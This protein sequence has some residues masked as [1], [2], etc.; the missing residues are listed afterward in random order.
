[1]ETS[2]GEALHDDDDHE[3]QGARLSTQKRGVDDII[4]SSRHFSGAAEP[5]TKAT[6]VFQPR[7]AAPKQSGGS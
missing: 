4:R 7:R 1:M 3:A 5:T 6:T 2:P